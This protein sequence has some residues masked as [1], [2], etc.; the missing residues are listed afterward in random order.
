M[1]SISVLIV[2]DQQAWQELYRDILASSGYFFEVAISFEKAIEKLQNKDFDVAI[3]DKRLNDEIEDD[4]GG[5][6]VLKWL[7]DS[8]KKTKVIL[9]SAAPIE[10]DI[11]YAYET[12]NIYHFMDKTSLSAVDLI[13]HIKMIADDLD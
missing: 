11:K 1:K 4:E 5:I 6:E 12:A 9:I 2:E 3:L 13:G 7:V 8:G 10:Q